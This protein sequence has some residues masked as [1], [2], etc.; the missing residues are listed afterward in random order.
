MGGLCKE[1]CEE[2]RGL[3]YSFNHSLS[4]THSLSLIILPNTVCCNYFMQ[5]LVRYMYIISFP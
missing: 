2:G 4:F 5:V 1:R 3:S